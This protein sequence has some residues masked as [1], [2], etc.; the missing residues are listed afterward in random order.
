MT[1]EMADTAKSAT[2]GLIPNAKF[3]IAGIELSLQVHVVRQAPFRALLGRPF[4]TVM[5]CK[6]KDY[7]SGDQHITLSDPN[8]RSRHSK[9]A[10]GIRNMLR[11]A[12]QQ[13]FQ[14]T[15]RN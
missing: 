7:T 13:G 9:V 2:I 5:E 11:N 1:I 3:M 8:D 14:Q 6:T 15:S 4:F 12:S 10:T